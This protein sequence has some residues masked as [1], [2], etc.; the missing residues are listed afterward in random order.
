MKKNLFFGILASML[1]TLSIAQQAN[2]RYS[3]DLN[4]RKDDTFKVTLQV[5]KLTDENDVYQFASTA[6]G[7]YQIMNLGRFVSDFKAFDKKGKEIETKNISVNQWKIENPKKVKTISYTIAETW[8]TPVEEYKI[9]KMCGTSIED[10]HVL[11]NAH[12]VFGYLTDM[13][14]EPIS[15][16]LAYP[17]NWKVGTALNTNE[18]GAYYATSYD[19]A[20]DSPIL[21]GRLTTASTNLN[22]SSIEIYTY[23]KTDLISS[24]QL[25]ASMT[26]MLKAAGEFVVNFPVDRYAFLYHFEDESW[27]AWEHS[28]SSEYVMKEEKY[29]PAFG[30]NIT[31]IAAHEFFHVVTPLNIHSEIIQEFNFVTPTPSEHLWLYEGTTEWAAHMMQLRYGLISVDD[32]FKMLSNKLVTDS[33][34]DSNYSL[35]KLALTSYTKDGYKQYNNIYMRGALVAGLL[36]IKLL[37]LSGGKRG[38]R[39]VINELSKK[40]GPTTPFSEKD[41]FKE[42]VAMTYPEIEDFFEQYVKN[43]NPLPV[44]EYY[45]KLGI[46]YSPKVKTGKQVATL[47]MHIGVPEGKFTFMKVNDELLKLGLQAND[48]LVAINGEEVIMENAQSIFVGLRKLEIG[49]EYKIMAR[50]DDKEFEV[51]AQVYSQEKINKHVFKLM[52]DISNNQ[53]EL[54]EAWLK[55]F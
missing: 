30:Q 11:I 29:T 48:Q 49:E 27:G 1:C 45:G 17:E 55:N 47:G 6:P 14:S 52:D 12:C 35:S 18:G 7:T 15:I 33:Y 2:L 26:S 4:E 10:D 36:D 25:L 31:D 13:Q 32:Y 19:H 22:G 3:I 16:D 43:A 20:V 41:F 51:T 28:Y 21:L 9:Y 37:E 46:S 34:F 39:E 24:E 53:I 23:S 8:D 50:R 44:S 40:Y 5:D 42:F 54:R 38:Y